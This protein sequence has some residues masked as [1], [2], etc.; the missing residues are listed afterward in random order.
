MKFIHNYNDL[1]AFTEDYNGSGYT[2]PWVSYIHENGKVNYN[3]QDLFFRI[4]Q[5]MAS[6]GD[7]A[8]ESDY[9]ESEMNIIEN[10]FDYFRLVNF[11]PDVPGEYQVNPVDDIKLYFVGGVWGEFDT[12]DPRTYIRAFTPTTI[13]FDYLFTANPYGFQEYRGRLSFENERY[14]GYADIAVRVDNGVVRWIEGDS[15]DEYE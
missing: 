14:N 13:S 8:R 12:D 10:F 15:F 1:T 4:P 9:T 7:S 2:E 3:K 11:N 5:Y 6:G